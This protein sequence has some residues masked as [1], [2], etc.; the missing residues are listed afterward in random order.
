[1]ACLGSKSVIFETKIFEHI[2]LG[3]F[4][5]LSHCLI[6]VSPLACTVTASSPILYA[7]RSYALPRSPKPLFLCSMPPHGFKFYVIFKP[8][9]AR[10]IH[11]ISPFFV[12]STQLTFTFSNRRALCLIIPEGN[13]LLNPQTKA[14][15]VLHWTFHNIILVHIKVP[16]RTAKTSLSSKTCSDTT[17]NRKF[18]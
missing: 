6:N 4:C 10:P 3:L 17:S 2:W 16:G 14:C 13:L 11:P 9:F 12:I 18:E 15:F 7:C 8:F 1:M 5:L